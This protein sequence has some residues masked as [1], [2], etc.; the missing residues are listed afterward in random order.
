MKARQVEELRFIAQNQK[1]CLAIDGSKIR[2]SHADMV[3]I[4]CINIL[5]NITWHRWAHFQV[6]VKFLPHNKAS[7]LSNTT[8]E[9]IDTE[10]RR[11]WMLQWCKISLPTAQHEIWTFRKQK[12]VQFAVDFKLHL[13]DYFFLP[14]F[15]CS[16]SALMVNTKF[17]QWLGVCL[18]ICWHQLL[19]LH[20]K[21]FFLIYSPK[22]D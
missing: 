9:L 8:I 15:D 18:S 3:D 13:V 21:K 6:K 19:Q 10:N 20:T 12:F 5:P 11:D 2:S 16:V 1:N 17:M 22:N 7:K 14:H 4:Q